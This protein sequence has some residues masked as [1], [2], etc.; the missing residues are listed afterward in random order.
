MQDV[1]Q[2][3]LTTRISINMPIQRPN[4]RTSLKSVGALFLALIWVAALPAQSVH[5]SLLLGD[6]QYL[7]DNFKEAEK[8]YRL[9]A[10]L[11]FSNPKALYNLGNA[12]YQQGKWSDAAERFAQAAKYAAVKADAANA[13]HNLGNALMKQQ[14]FKDAVESYENSLRLRPG[15]AET[16][17]NLQMAK[18]KLKEEEQKER[19]KAQQQQK[20]QEQDQ[21]QDQQQ[22]EQN[23]QEQQQ[24]QQQDQSGKPKEQESQPEQSQP[25][26]MKKEEAQ[27]LLE[28]AVDPEDQRNARKYRSAQQKN[29]GN[30]ARKDW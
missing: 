1:S 30:T 17:M 7:R 6:R 16:K 10:D 9:A 28:T 20:Q 22:Q 19:E 13:L 26:K 3:D 21:Q 11:E 12:L 18:K 14:K 15:D 4:N 25:G 5:Q 2:N 24:D 27:R 8:E 23:K 29:R